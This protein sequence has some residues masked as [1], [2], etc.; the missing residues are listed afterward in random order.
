MGVFFPQHVE[1][2]TVLNTTG[3]TICPNTWIHEKCPDSKT[4]TS[5]KEKTTT[6]SRSYLFEI[7]LQLFIISEEGWRETLTL[8]KK[9]KNSPKKV[10]VT[11]IKTVKLH[12]PAIFWHPV[13][14]NVFIVFLI[15]V[16][17]VFHHA[18]IK[19]EEMCFTNALFHKS[20]C[21]CA[22]V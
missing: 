9:N 19:E 17:F 4:V 14:Q 7:I 10:P 22:C 18:P 15:Y 1:N 8:D 21:V 5:C 12:Y 13:P 16:L 2:I 11:Y 6:R 20:V 3:L